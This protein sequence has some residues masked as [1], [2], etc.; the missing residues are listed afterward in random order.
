MLLDGWMTG[1][2]GCAVHC[3]SPT[4]SALMDIKSS[5][6]RQVHVCPPFRR[7]AEEEPGSGG[8]DPKEPAEG[9]RWV[10]HG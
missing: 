5:V 2:C 3:R 10:P 7:R 8:A 6:L 4:M 1:G 9:A